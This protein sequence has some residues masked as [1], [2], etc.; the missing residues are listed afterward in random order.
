MHP[1]DMTAAKAALCR[2]DTM[3]RCKDCPAQNLPHTARTAKIWQRSNK[4]GMADP[5]RPAIDRPAFASPRANQL[6]G[7]FTK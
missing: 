6:T 2:L 7:E 1:A 4:V 5:V 3:R